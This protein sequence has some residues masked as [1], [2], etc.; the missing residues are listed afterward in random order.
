MKLKFTILA[1]AL[2]LSAGPPARAE[3]VTPADAK[4]AAQG[5]VRMIERVKGHWGTAVNPE[6]GQ[7]VPLQANN[8][9]VG[10]YCP[11]LSG[12][13]VVV[14]SHKELEPV[15]AYSVRGGLDP[16]A[17]RGPSA[18]VREMQ[19][20]VVRGLQKAI[21]PLDSARPEQFQA[22]LKRDYRPH[23]KKLQDAAANPSGISPQDATYESGGGVLLSDKWNQ[24]PPYNY[25]CPNQGC[26]LGC[27]NGGDNAVVGCVPLSG[28]QIM[29]YWCWP[30]T[31][32]WTS[33]PNNLDCASPFAEIDAVARLC[34]D[35]GG[36]ITDNSSWCNTGYGCD[37]TSA[38]LYCGT[39]LNCTTMHDVYQDNFGFIVTDNGSD[40][41]G[42]ADEWW[43]G[44]TNEL[45]LKQPVHY[46]MDTS[47]PGG[48]AFVVDGWEVVSGVQKVHVNYGWGGDVIEWVS[49]NSLPESAGN[50][51]RLNN[52]KPAFSI[53]P[54][55]LGSYPGP[56]YFNQTAICPLNA[57]FQPPL[58]WLQF[59]PS[60]SLSHIGPLGAI[61]FRGGRAP[62]DSRL[63]AQGDPTKGIRIGVF[64]NGALKLTGRGSLRLVPQIPPRY[65]TYER[66]G[67]LVRLA[68]ERGYSDDETTV[69]ERNSGAGW[70][71]VWTVPAA[72][73]A[74]IDPFAPS[75]SRYR[76]RSSARGCLSSPSD[77]VC[78]Q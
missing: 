57:T 31:Y 65:P 47:P 18:L 39:C 6:I 35:I 43:S 64:G 42:T 7:V 77:E 10:Y 3:T 15:R 20:V 40:R 67:S 30:A 59:L 8:R 73:T 24:T 49:L 45:S 36:P 71:I 17:S 60:I 2:L 14:S 12:G 53:G 26:G 50:E 68:W 56:Q 27:T 48:H 46:K 61:T 70:V 62:F 5:W 34:S 76:L 38:I 63:F 51:G 4:A 78:A 44:I 52:V 41:S 32:A 55:L 74:H 33:M 21:G 29:R 28:A 25:Y 58:S 69:I 9:V 22:L 75:G 66:Y 16:Q 13:Y 19:D 72:V 54:L 23:W 37:G 1:S 11:V